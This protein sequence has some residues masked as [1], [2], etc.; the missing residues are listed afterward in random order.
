MGIQGTSVQLELLGPLELRLQGR[1]VHAGGPKQRA[2][3]GYL[4]LHIN[5][6][7]QIP[8]LINAVWGE[9]PSDGAVR[10]LRTYLSN[11]RRILGSGAEISSG[12]GSYRL[13]LPS[14][15]TDV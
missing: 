8:I 5:E 12:S 11:L 1:V 13:S 14:S 4:A 3:L 7:V 10:S 6:F 9:D 15:D 2:L